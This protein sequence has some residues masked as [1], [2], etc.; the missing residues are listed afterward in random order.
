[1]TVNEP[2]DRDELTFDEWPITPDPDGPI[3]GAI[4]ETGGQR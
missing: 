3:P 4:D 1:M 2:L